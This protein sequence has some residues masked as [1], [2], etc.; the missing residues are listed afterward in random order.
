MSD[1]K[2]MFPLPTFAESRAA[3][4]CVPVGGVA[5][6]LHH[7]IYDNT[8]GGEAALETTFREQLSDVLLEVTTE[9]RAKP[10]GEL[11]KIETW[12]ALH[13][14]FAEG[15][16]QDEKGAEGLIAA[17]DRLK[18]DRDRLL[19]ERDRAVAHAVRESGEAFAGN[20]EAVN[21]LGLDT[22]TVQPLLM[23]V[24][25]WDITT[26]RAR[27]LLRCWILGTFKPEQLPPRKDLGL[28]ETDDPG[29]VLQKLRAEAAFLLERLADFDQSGDMDEVASREFS[30][31]VAPSASRLRGLLPATEKEVADAPA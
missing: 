1:A 7:F 20:I 8:P 31:H 12:I 21:K 16:N 3:V 19:V 10:D 17:L 23:A 26:G 27:E 9:A 18:A 5:S 15:P 25:S 2:K 4:G 28:A 13:T 24:Q 11:S 22:M 30:G 6:P 14:D 29:D